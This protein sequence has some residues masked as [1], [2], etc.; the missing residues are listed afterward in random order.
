MEDLR[1]LLVVNTLPPHD[2]SGVGEQIFQLNDALQKKGIQTLL[3]GRNKNSKGLTS[4]KFLFP[5]TVLPRVLKALS[6]FSPNV[7]QVHESDGFMVN[8]AVKIWNAITGKK[9]KIITT[10]AVTYVE[11]AKSVKE[12]VWENEVLS[13][14][15]LTE[16][17][18]KYF[19]API[20]TSAG[21]LSCYLSDLIL[22]QGRTTASEIKDNYKVAE[23]PVKIIPNIAAKRTRSAISEKLPEEFILFVGRL[24]IRK[25][26]EYLIKAIDIVRKRGKD[27]SLVI[28]G[29]GE[30]RVNIEKL[31][32]LL[33]LKEKVIFLGKKS[34]EEVR[35]VISRAKVVVIP[36][37]YEGMPLVILESMY[38][39]TP[40]IATKVAS[41]PEVV[42]DGYNGVLVSPEN[43]LEL[44][45]AIYKL[46]ED[47][48]F[49]SEIAERAK[50]SL[51]EYTPDRIA[52]VWVNHV[53]SIM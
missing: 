3:L 26:V 10:L 23:V 36:S 12:L 27:I 46:V 34:P 37:I 32:A 21:I 42:K 7:V 52:S 24:R 31:V 40:V 44:A 1:V 43:P 18:F 17:L 49:A 22:T 38:E 16:I 6:R 35:Y 53:K 5:I 9:V 30:N 4:K 28:L 33:S 47:E 8:V 19:K 39:G 50:E 14:P 11:E 15:T 29:D 48:K 51:V 20:M 41:I 45:D 25:A 2:I 13:Y